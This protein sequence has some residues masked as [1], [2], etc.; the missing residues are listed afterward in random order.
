M[1]NKQPPKVFI[2]YAWE[3]D[4]KS[5][6]RD[7]ALH[8]RE[9]G[10]ETILDQWEMHLGDQLAE[11]MESSVRNS[12]FVLI[13]CT[14]KYKAK[15]DDRKGGV[16]Y[17]GHIITA[18][19]FQKNNHRKFIPVLRKD[20]WESSSPSWA[21]GKLYIDL[22]GEPYNQQNYQDLL[23][24]L[25]GMPHTP[26]PLGTPPSF[27][28]GPNNDEIT[29]NQDA[30]AIKSI[31][32]LIQFGQYQEA[33]RKC[34]S[35]LSID[36]SP[37]IHLLAAI[38]YSLNKRNKLRENDWEIIERHISFAMQDEE[39]RSTALA[40]LGCLKHSPFEINRLPDASKLSLSF[41]KRELAKG[42]SIDREIL[43]LVKPIP[44]EL[45]Y[46]GIRM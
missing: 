31:K 25:H 33:H 19:I 40:V 20:N 4:I 22:K 37:I 46:L 26:P 44:D 24:T 45:N 1:E 34:V 10:V 21:M 36:N 39:I 12:D 11:F 28:E 9:D 30:N 13:V 17:E 16:G 23:R 41:I 35:L 15:S 27:P 29:H 38:A 6:V 32:T 7:L 18:E 2:S 8:L 14:P 5:W 42:Y 43:S 3:N